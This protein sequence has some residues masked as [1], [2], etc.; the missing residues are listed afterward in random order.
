M[1]YDRRPGRSCRQTISPEAADSKMVAE[2]VN[3]AL[4]ASR[5]GWATTVSKSGFSIKISALSA[6]LLALSACQTPDP[7]I[8]S[9]SAQ[10]DEKIGRLMPRLVALASK[11]LAGTGK[12]FP[13]YRVSSE[14]NSLSGQPRIL[15]V[16]R[17]DTQGLPGLVILGQVQD[18]GTALSVFGRL[19]SADGDRSVVRNVRSW[20]DGGTDCV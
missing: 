5:Y 19:L 18:N 4:R 2:K 6:V 20:A 8:T 9:F 14:L 17:D 15:L 10:S 12:P 3:S 16:R 11:C 13:Q 1:C 7:G